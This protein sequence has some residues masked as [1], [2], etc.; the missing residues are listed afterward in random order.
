[1]IGIC[2]DSLFFDSLETDHERVWFTIAENITKDSTEHFAMT[3]F[4]E[5]HFYWNFKLKLF[6]VNN[7]THMHQYHCHYR[8]VHRRQ[9]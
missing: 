3:H 1:M 9:L 7:I 6:E 5:A 4:K 2:L 8:I